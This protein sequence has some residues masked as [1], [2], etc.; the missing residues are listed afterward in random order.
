MDIGHVTLNTQIIF[1]LIAQPIVYMSIFCNPLLTLMSF[2]T[3][4]TIFFLW[5]HCFSPYIESHWGLLLITFS[6]KLPPL[7]WKPCLLPQVIVSIALFSRSRFD[8]KRC[9]RRLNYCSPSVQLLITLSRSAG[10]HHWLV[11]DQLKW[12]DSR[13]EQERLRSHQRKTV[14]IQ[15]LL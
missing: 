4:M 13:K 11:C 1:K 15:H 2:Q 7:L 5:L 9:W 8:L 10:S 12:L 6:E 3:C 14:R